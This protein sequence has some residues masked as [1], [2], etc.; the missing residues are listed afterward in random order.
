M[1]RE[2]SPKPRRFTAPSWQSEVRADDWLMVLV[3]Q[4]G[5]VLFYLYLP[6]KTSCCHCN[7]HP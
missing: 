2:M 4:G 5:V 1:V 3:K 7:R 6:L